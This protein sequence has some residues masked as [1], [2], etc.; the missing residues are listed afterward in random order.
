MTENNTNDAGRQSFPVDDAAV[1]GADS[2]G[3][4][5]STSSA[6][7]ST[8][9]NK[10]RKISAPKSRRVPK[11]SSASKRK[12]D[13][14][15]TGKRPAKGVRNRRNFIIGFIVVIV[16][17]DIAILS[18]VFFSGLGPSAPPNSNPV[19]LIQEQ[20][21]IE[22]TIPEIGYDSSLT[23]A[24]HTDLTIANTSSM[25]P[26][27]NNLLKKGAGPNGSD[28]LYDALIVNRVLRLNT[29]WI[30]YLNQ[31]NQKVFDSLSSDPKSPA[32]N[33]LIEL[34]GKSQIAFH[35]IALGEIRHIGSK[36][37]ILAEV[38][39]ILVHDGQQESFDD[40]FVYEL[41]RDGSTMVVGDFERIPQIKAPAQAQTPPPDQSEAVTDETTTEVAPEDATEEQPEGTTEEESETEP[42][43][44][45][46]T[47]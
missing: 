11:D 38:S 47:P 10:P 3:T 23:F 7:S 15:D 34:G 19:T 35:R 42:E 32:K 18:V 8:T 33:K 6:D 9:K 12:G 24:N 14:N 5:R 44:E 27:E 20:L 37:Y 29:D 13:S 30:D 28:L 31:G 43:P 2:T 17:F 45:T 25:K 22:N 39:Y 1:P 4:P 16:I 46:E 41:I 40:L 36:Y 21:P 26:I